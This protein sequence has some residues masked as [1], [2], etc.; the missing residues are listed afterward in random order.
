MTA[1]QWFCRELVAVNP[2]CSIVLGV[3]KDQTVVQCEIAIAP[4]GVRQFQC[5]PIITIIGKLIA[6]NSNDSD[7]TVAGAAL[8]QSTLASP[9]FLLLDVSH[10]INA[11]QATL[12]ILA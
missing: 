12:C 7:Q 8:V 4:S 6:N 9:T 11:H 5:F 10:T 2:L 1:V 3:S